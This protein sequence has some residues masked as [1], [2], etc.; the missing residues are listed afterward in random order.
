MYLLSDEL[1]NLANFK[2]PLSK[3]EVILYD[4]KVDELNKIK[5]E[6]NT[7]DKNIESVFNKF[8][9]VLE[10]KGVLLGVWI[11]I[12]GVFIINNFQTNTFSDIIELAVISFFATICLILFVSILVVILKAIN[13]NGVNISQIL[14]YSEVRSAQKTRSLLYEKIS[15]LNKGIAEIETKIFEYYTNQLEM[16]FN[17]YLYKKRSSNTHFQKSISTF[18]K[19]L[20]SLEKLNKSLITPYLKI[21][22]RDYKNYVL[23]RAIS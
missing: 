9:D 22:L 5:N 7:I 17:N 4:K 13:I 19:L 21:E 8:D 16:F 20:D 12:I 2:N 14:Q 6:I 1:N 23:G 15:I 18:S 3:D 10:I 11:F